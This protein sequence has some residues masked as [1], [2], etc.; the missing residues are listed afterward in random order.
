M[1][2][3]T[4]VRQEILY[5]ISIGKMFLVLQKFM[6]Q[7][8]VLGFDMKYRQ[9][10]ICTMQS[11]FLSFCNS[12]SHTVS[13]PV[14]RRGTMESKLLLINE[15]FLL[16]IAYR[17]YRVLDSNTVSMETGHSD[18]SNGNMF[19]FYIFVNIYAA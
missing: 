3:H 2:S 11:L 1:F 12:F 4:T 13:S 9:Q 19:N 14:P 18:F 8:A 10:R 7:R 16:V 17:I 6:I 5:I 15:T